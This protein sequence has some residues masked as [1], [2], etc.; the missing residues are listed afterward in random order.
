MYIRGIILI[1]VSILC[2]ILTQ[3][4]VLMDYGTTMRLVSFIS[5]AIGCCA[6]IYLLS[7]NKYEKENKHEQL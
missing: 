7:I 4:N 6:G 3:Y 1:V 2:F 5:S